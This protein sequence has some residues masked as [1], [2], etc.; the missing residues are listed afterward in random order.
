MLKKWIDISVRVQ[1]IFNCKQCDK[2]GTVEH[3]DPSP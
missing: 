2:A 1:D 3:T